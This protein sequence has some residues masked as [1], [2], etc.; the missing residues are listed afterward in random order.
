MFHV[1]CLVKVAFT[2]EGFRDWKNSKVRIEA[3]ENSDFHKTNVSNL[4]AR[5]VVQGR[6]DERLIKQLNEE[7]L[8]WKKIL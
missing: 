8:Y 4:K 7:I 6:V 1:Y 3:H 5:A 2:G